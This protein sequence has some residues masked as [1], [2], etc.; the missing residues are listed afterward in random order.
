MFM[1][2][3]TLDRIRARSP[4]GEG[5]TGY[6]GM[7]DSELSAI[8]KSDWR[9]VALYA[10]KMVRYI[11][12]PVGNAVE[13]LEKGDP[14]GAALMVEAPPP[15]ASY[16]ERQASNCVV[17]AASC[18]FAEIPAAIARSALRACALAAFALSTQAQE[19]VPYGRSTTLEF[20]DTWISVRDAQAAFIDVRRACPEEGIEIPSVRGLTHAAMLVHLSGVCRV[21]YL[22]DNYPEI[23]GASVCGVLLAGLTYDHFR[24]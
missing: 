14:R 12:K 9:D 1:I 24:P 3:T 17:A 6:E 13:L 5:M 15:H 7:T 23:G 11:S 8:S 20:V 21:Y 10:A 18:Y 16:A 22:R 4:C 19:T 2:C